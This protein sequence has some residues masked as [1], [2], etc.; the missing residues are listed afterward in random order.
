MNTPNLVDILAQKTEPKAN[1]TVNENDFTAAAE[2]VTPNSDDFAPPPQ[3]KADFTQLTNQPETTPEN[4]GKNGREKL[5][6]EEYE[7]MAK[8]ALG[9]AD[10]FNIFVMP[11]LYQ[12]ALF[13]KAELPKVRELVKRQKRD[14]ILGK[15]ETEYTE[16]ELKLLEKIQVF[17]DAKEKLP[18]EDS[19]VE[20]L[21]KTLGGLFEKYDWRIGKETE[22]IG[23]L[24]MAFLPRFL[25][26]FNKLTV[27]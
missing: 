6:K 8:N 18:F 19:E 5:S 13:N 20:T 27:I 3:P 23:V 12:K 17:K 24:S 2:T 9:L 16:D 1:A 11:I 15:I 26:L 22:A 25:P 7:R 14:A 10:G 4:V 21:A